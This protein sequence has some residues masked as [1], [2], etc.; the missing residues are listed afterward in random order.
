[1]LIKKFSNIALPSNRNFGFFFTTVFVLFGAY[2]LVYGK[3]NIAIPIFAIGTLLLAITLL[4]EELLLPLNKLWMLIGLLLGIIV[5]PIV[6]SIIYFGLF[7]PIAYGMR[8]VG[9]DELRLK[10]KDRTSF[11]RLKETSGPSVSTFKNQF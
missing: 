9:R 3:T 7:V 2:L 11:W 4:K 8:L 5:S 1:M 10:S 6:L